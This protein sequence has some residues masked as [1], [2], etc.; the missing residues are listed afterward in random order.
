MDKAKLYADKC[1][2]LKPLWSK[3]WY[4]SG[5]VLMQR[6]NYIDACHAFE[7][8]FQ[9]D[10]E[11]AELKRSYIECAHFAKR[12]G[13]GDPGYDSRTIGMLMTIQQGSWVFFL[14]LCR[15]KT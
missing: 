8:G 6:E 15:F 3:G 14:F 10:P 2:Q 1:T 5:K 13:N 11:N 4:R 9:M 7:K 12:L